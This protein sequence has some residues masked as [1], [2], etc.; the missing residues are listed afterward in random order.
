[1]SATPTFL[2]PLRCAFAAG[3]LALLVAAVLIIPAFSARYSLAQGDVA[4]ATIKSP[5]YVPPFPSDS[6]TAERKER[7]AENVPDVLILDAT[8]L[9][10]QVTRG[11]TLFQQIGRAH[12]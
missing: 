2:T 6:L 1:M 8:V 4:A 11:R 10:R 12:V 9:A 5:R 7:V 3:L